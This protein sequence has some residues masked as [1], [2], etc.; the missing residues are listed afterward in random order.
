MVSIDDLVGRVFHVEGGGTLILESVYGGDETISKIAARSRNKASAEDI[1]TQIGRMTKQGHTTPF[2]FARLTLDIHVPMDTWRQWVRHRT[3]TALERSTRY[4]ES[5]FEFDYAR[6]KPEDRA[7]VASSLVSLEQV[8]RRLRQLGYEREIARKVLPMA[9][10]TSLYW[11]SD[12]HNLR[13]FLRQRLHRSAQQDIRRYAEII[14]YIMSVW[15]PITWKHFVATLD[16]KYY[17]RL[18]PADLA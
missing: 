14:S 10:F 18:L 15:C 1:D 13:G 5:D 6:I 2:E 7:F 4:T 12:L 11:T 3:S 17:P 8:Y 16:K 9:T